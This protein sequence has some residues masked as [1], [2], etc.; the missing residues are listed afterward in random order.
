MRRNIIVVICLLISFQAYRMS[1]ASI[2]REHSTSVQ[3]F[4]TKP[5]V[6]IDQYKGENIQGMNMLIS[7]CWPMLK[8]KQDFFSDVLFPTGFQKHLSN[9]QRMYELSV[10]EDTTKRLGFADRAKVESLLEG[11]SDSRIEGFYLLCQYPTLISQIHFSKHTDK[12]IFEFELLQRCQNTKME[13]GEDQI[14]KYFQLE[15]SMTESVFLD[16]MQ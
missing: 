1:S 15:R 10:L 13:V 6:Q 5:C 9:Y 12:N 3:E 4:T 14:Q 2:T 11:D 16:G 7:N 8:N